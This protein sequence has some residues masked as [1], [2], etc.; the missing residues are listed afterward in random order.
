M[1]EN[2]THWVKTLDFKK[3]KT[4]YQIRDQNQW[5]SWQKVSKIE[6]RMNTNRM[7]CKKICKVYFLLAQT[8]C[9]VVKVPCRATVAASLMSRQGWFCYP[10]AVIFVL[11]PPVCCQ[12]LWSSREASHPQF[13]SP[14]FFTSWYYYRGNNPLHPTLLSCVSTHMQSSFHQ[15]PKIALWINVVDSIFTYMHHKSGYI[16]QK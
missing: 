4:K 9:N 2:N 12:Y 3:S 8:Q 16:N 15:E 5:Q 13:I 10:F 11:W 7:K 14:H 1:V 6:A